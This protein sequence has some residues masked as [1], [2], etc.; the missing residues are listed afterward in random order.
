MKGLRGFAVESNEV[1]EQFRPA[2]SGPGIFHCPRVNAPMPIAALGRCRPST[3]PRT[4]PV[5]RTPPGTGAKVGPR[6]VNMPDTISSGYLD[7]LPRRRKAAKPQPAD[8]LNPAQDRSKVPPPW[9]MQLSLSGVSRGWSL[10][11]PHQHCWVL[12][13]RQLRVGRNGATVSGVNCLALPRP[14]P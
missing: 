6:P 2:R 9:P 8:P 12:P 14:R 13:R 11:H 4:A 7:R 1:E 3:L 10:L 5:G